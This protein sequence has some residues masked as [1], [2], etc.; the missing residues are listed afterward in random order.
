MRTSEADA[1]A[2]AYGGEGAD[3]AG[4]GPQAAV[5]AAGFPERLRKIVPRIARSGVEPSGHLDRHRWVI[6]RT[7]YWL[8]GCRRLHHRYQRTVDQ[9]LA[10]VGIAC[11]LICYRRSVQV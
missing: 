9:F 8:K 11:T 3:G 5:T 7:M 4:Q 1:H 6:E 10:F 2:D